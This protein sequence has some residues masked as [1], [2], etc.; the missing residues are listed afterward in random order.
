MKKFKCQT[1]NS[2]LCGE[3]KKKILQ[4]K[5]QQYTTNSENIIKQKYNSNS[6]SSVVRKHPFDCDNPLINIRKD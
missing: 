3:I 5:F 4:T 1:K 6:P 2:V